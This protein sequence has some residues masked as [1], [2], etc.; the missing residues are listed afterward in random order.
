MTISARHLKL[1]EV[2]HANWTGHSHSLRAVPRQPWWPMR[3][4]LA[5]RR[6]AMR[7]HHR[8]PWTLTSI[9]C[10]TLPRVEHAPAPH[11]AGAPALHPA[12]ETFH[13]P[14]IQ[15]PAPATLYSRDVGPRADS[16]DSPGFRCT[17]RHSACNRSSSPNR[18]HPS[19]SAFTETNRLRSSS[20]TR[21]RLRG[22]HPRAAPAFAGQLIV[23][24]A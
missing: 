7:G 23:P 6:T 24:D 5:T 11:P 10:R 2:S 14:R 18:S 1:K 20:P 3:F 12:R 22:P 17:D 16:G 8:R 19:P 4:I 13:S 21:S 9:M 15:A